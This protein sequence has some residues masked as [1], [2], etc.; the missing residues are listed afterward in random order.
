MSQIT[1]ILNIYDSDGT[2]SDSTRNV[3]IEN[4]LNLNGGT[5]NITGSG[6]TA[7]TSSQVWYNSSNAELARMLDSGGLAIGINSLTGGFAAAARF[8]ADASVSADYTNTAVL[9]QTYANTSNNTN[10]ST[11]L[12]TRLYKT[13]TYNTSEMKAAFI[14]ARN[15]GTGSMNYICGTESMLWSIGS[16]TITSAF[17]TSARAQIQAGTITNFGGIDVSFQ[18]VAGGTITNMIGVLVRTPTNVTG[19]TI[20]NTYGVL[21]Q[22]NTIGT[23]DYGFVS[24]GQASNGLGTTT[25]SANAILDLQSTTKA[26]K[27]PR[28]NVTEAGALTAEDSMMIY[29][30]N[31]DATFPTIGAYCRENGAW[32]KH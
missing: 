28:M 24:A 7:A 29:V 18:E 21:V 11:T 30:T 14:Q 9:D 2:I 5:V 27:L 31:T 8:R 22:D 19:G 17:S 3:E 13:S 12:T 26:F 4:I 10:T 20:T 32:V 6:S 25:P 23:N 15:D 16:A 1:K